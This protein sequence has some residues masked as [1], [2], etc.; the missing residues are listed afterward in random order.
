MRRVLPGPIPACAGEPAHTSG[1]RRSNRAYPRVRGGTAP[2]RLAAHACRGLSPRA[3]GNPQGRDPPGH[4]GGPI[5]ACAGEPAHRTRS[6]IT[7]EAYPRVRGG[8]PAE[9]A[10]ANFS[11]GLS[12]RARGN[13]GRVV[14]RHGEGG[15][16]PACAGEPGEDASVFFDE[17][18]YPRVRGGTPPLDCPEMVEQG[19]SPRARGN[20]ESPPDE[21]RHHGPIPAC[22]GEPASRPSRSCRTRAYPRVRGGT[23]ASVAH[24]T[25]A[26]GLSPRA[27][28]NLWGFSPICG[29]RARHVYSQ[30]C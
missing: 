21:A 2:C 12:P 9:I 25:P 22:A 26:A 18:A 11:M 24:S 15:P 6:R 8:T 16:I 7:C 27:R 13:P 20:H 14:G 19:L 4:H 3:R 30:P 28:G 17:K 10:P 23:S 5:P 1:G 29:I